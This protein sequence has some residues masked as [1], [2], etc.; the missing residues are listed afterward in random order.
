MSGVPILVDVIVAQA[1]QNVWVNHGAARASVE[2]QPKGA[3]A[4]RP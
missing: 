2:H 3:I 1:D 4:G